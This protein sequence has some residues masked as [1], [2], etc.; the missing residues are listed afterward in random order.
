MRTIRRA[1]FYLVAFISVLALVWGVTNLLRSLFRQDLLGDQASILSMGLAQVLVSIPFFLLHWLV[2]ERD[3]RLSEEEQHSGIRALFLYAILI[4]LLIPVVQNGIAILNRAFL[5]LFG[6][7]PKR[8]L[9]GGTQ[10]LADNLIAMG[11]NFLFAIYFCRALRKDWEAAEGTEN[12]Q[13]TRR[14]YRHAWMLYGLGLAVLGVQRLLVFML[15]WNIPLGGSI[16]QQ[17]SNALTLLLMGLPLWVYWWRL[18]DNTSDLETER[19][20]W[21]RALVPFAIALTGAIVLAVNSGRVLYFGLGVLFGRAASLP[22]FL[23]DIASALSMALP[24]GVLNRYYH[25]KLFG[26]PSSSLD[27]LTSGA[28]KRVY[29][30]ILSAAGLGAVIYGMDGLAAYLVNSVFRPVLSLTDWREAL[31]VSLAVLAVGMALWLAHWRPLESA[32]AQSGA[33]GEPARRALSRKI[34]L[35]LAVFACV[36][37]TMLSAGYAIYNTLQIWLAAAQAPALTTIFHNLHTLAIFALFLTYHLGRLA[38]D[39]RLQSTLQSNRQ[40]SFKVLALLQPD[41]ASASPLRQA[42]Q[43]HAA[44]IGLETLPAASLTQGSLAGVDLV[45]LECGLL[46]STGI[47]QELLR[48]V[49][50]EVIVIPDP[51][52]LY[53]WLGLRAR[54]SEVFNA[55][56]QAAL[57]L[58]DGQAIKQPGAS[59]PWLM[60]GYVFAGLFALLLSLMGFSFLLGG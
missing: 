50:G 30:S 25:H 20:S 5:T 29:H 4:S 35:Y 33:T 41:S 24:F 38:S 3:A 57:S 7:N 28:L 32:A 56:A 43:R 36:I 51:A 22:G 15:S 8:A 60:L 49:A 47:T 1:Y 54:P 42:F 21:L 53:T 19:H 58:A 27:W 44:G 39:N 16:N 48:G 11:I 55:C 59:S 10:N 40:A 18:L 2:V 14:L 34:Y 17:L 45:I 23:T 12:L 13:D 6:L 37:G 46:E 52:S 26:K 31:T 9:F